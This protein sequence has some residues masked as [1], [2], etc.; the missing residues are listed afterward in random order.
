MAAQGLNGI[1]VFSPYGIMLSFH[2]F[3][4]KNDMGTPVLRFIRG[5]DVSEAS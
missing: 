1:F 2:G 3:N 5:Q 4:S